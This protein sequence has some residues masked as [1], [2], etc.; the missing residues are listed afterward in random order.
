MSN[1]LTINITDQP[2]FMAPPPELHLCP[3][4]M[5][6]IIVPPVVM[7]LKL[8][9]FNLVVALVPDPR[10]MYL[11]TSFRTATNTFQVVAKMEQTPKEVLA[12]TFKESDVPVCHKLSV[13]QLQ[14]YRWKRSQLNTPS[15][16]LPKIIPVRSY[17]TS[18]IQQLSTSLSRKIPLKD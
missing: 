6:L 15:D 5:A 18:P 14:A 11:I 8:R 7:I 17:K 12:A 3:L 16:G 2:V 10:G 1:K 9:M 13:F 4:C